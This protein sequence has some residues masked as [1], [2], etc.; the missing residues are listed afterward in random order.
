M[1]GTSFK[2]AFRR[3]PRD[4][5]WG[6][7]IQS[8]FNLLYEVTNAG[9]RDFWIGRTEGD[10]L[11]EDNK[12]STEG[13]RARWNSKYIDE[14]MNRMVCIYATARELPEEEAKRK[15]EETEGRLIVTCKNFYP[16]HIKNEQVLREKT[17]DGKSVE[18]KPPYLVYVAYKE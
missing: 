10:P 9:G 5:E 16:R 2:D 8:V 6:E 17:Y 11:V 14:N 15:V 7:D 18:G 4:L 13:M 1:Q 12:V 3:P